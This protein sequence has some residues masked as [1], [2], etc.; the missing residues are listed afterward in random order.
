MIRA[1]IITDHS[2]RVFELA[3]LILGRRE[4]S[5]AVLQAALEKLSVTCQKEFKR[6]YFRDKH[7]EGATRVAILGSGLF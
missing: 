5:L 3:F 7:P 4:A 6:H 1:S 2:E